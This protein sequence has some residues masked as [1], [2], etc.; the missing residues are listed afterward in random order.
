TALVAGLA[1]LAAAAG[2]SP[3][4]VDVSRA[5]GSQWEVAVTADP[6]NG[7][8]L[9]AGSNQDFRPGV[10]ERVYASTDGG[11]S[12]SSADGPSLPTGLEGFCAADPAVAIASDAR[13]YYAFLALDCSGVGYQ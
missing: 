9:L 7:R 8:H 2:R 1:P 10:P 13:E 11:A 6:R 4:Q 3:M 12:W 5:A